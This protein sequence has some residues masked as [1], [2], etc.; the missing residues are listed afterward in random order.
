M[1]L[2]RKLGMTSDHT[3]LTAAWTQYVL[4]A[5]IALIVLLFALFYLVGFDIPFDENPDYN[6]PLLTGVLISFAILLLL[7]TTVLAI[8]SGVRSMYKYRSKQKKENGIRSARIIMAVSAGTLCMLLLSFLLAPIGAIKVNG[9][10]F[11]DGFWLRVAEMFVD[12]S[13]FL[14][15]AAFATVGIGYAI[16]VKRHNEKMKRRNQTC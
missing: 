13:L 11:T 7:V 8:V 12:T 10:L 9:V 16:R 6:A 15:L 3:G 4:Y 1:M 2:Q 5:L 14:L